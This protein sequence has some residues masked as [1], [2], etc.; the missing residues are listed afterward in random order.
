MS[1]TSELILRD[2]KVSDDY[3]SV[4]STLKFGLGARPD[5]PHR[6]L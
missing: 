3:A 2:F 1:S 5:H 4:V 6:A